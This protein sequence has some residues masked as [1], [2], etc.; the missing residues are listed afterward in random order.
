METMES[1]R[2]TYTESTVG[3]RWVP[4]G[5]RAHFR[6]IEQPQIFVFR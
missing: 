3:P 5:S 2:R 4:G 1:C 6:P